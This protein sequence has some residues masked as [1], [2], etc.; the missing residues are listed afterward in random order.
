MVGVK[1][2]T[3]AIFPC[4]FINGHRRSLFGAICFLFS[5]LLLQVLNGRK[6]GSRAHHNKT[7]QKQN[8]KP[9]KKQKPASAQPAGCV[10]GQAA[11]TRWIDDEQHTE[12][13]REL[14]FL[15]MSA[16][17]LALLLVTFW[18]VH[19][20]PRNPRNNGTLVT[21]P[22]ELMS[23]SSSGCVHNESLSERT[24]TQANE[25]RVW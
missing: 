17:T 5:L 21:P 22:R 18:S 16:F 3:P 6:F 11:H 14:I 12:C 1:H 8:K 13:K 24:S 7:S 15:I 23:R 19:R 25:S 10:R 4:L 20:S 9:R 2:K